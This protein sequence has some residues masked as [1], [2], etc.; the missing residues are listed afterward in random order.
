MDDVNINRAVHEAMG[1]LFRD[2]YFGGREPVSP[3][4]KIPDYCIDFNA[5]MTFAEKLI[6]DGAEIEMLTWDGGQWKV[7]VA[8]PR[9]GMVQDVSHRVRLTLPRAI[10]LAGL[11]ALGIEL[12]SQP[13]GETEQ[14]NQSVNKP[15]RK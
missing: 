4:E 10:C 9:N 3:F 14:L 11:S 2:S 15:D 1:C 12:Q 7:S 6:A 5:A 8:L 13:D